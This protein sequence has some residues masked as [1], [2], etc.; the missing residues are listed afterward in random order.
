M[1]LKSFCF[2]FQL[3]NNWSNCGLKNLFVIFPIR[4][5][6]GQYIGYDSDRS[7]SLVCMVHIYCIPLHIICIENENWLWCMNWLLFSRTQLFHS[8]VYVYDRSMNCALCIRKWFNGIFNILV[9]CNFHYMHG[10]FYSYW[11]SVV[12]ICMC[13]VL[14]VMYGERFE[15]LPTVKHHIFFY[16]SLC[17]IHNAVYRFLWIDVICCLYLPHIISSIFDTYL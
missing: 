13:E 4:I 11:F 16:F 2:V 6:C 8:T 14:I 5:N 15:I 9:N 7:T 1:V 3:S 17:G 12:N 10:F